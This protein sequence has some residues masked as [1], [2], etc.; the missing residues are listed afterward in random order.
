MVAGFA[1]L[2][3]AIN[4]PDGLVA[5]DYYKD[6]LAINRTLERDDEAQRLGAKARL[7]FDF[8]ANRVAAN[9]SAEP[10]ADQQ[11]RLRLT[12]PTL[13]DQDVT[14]LLRRAGDGTYHASLPSLAPGHW[15]VLLEPEDLFWRLTGRI[16]LPESRMLDLA[17][18]ENTQPQ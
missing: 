11:Y 18:Q 2:V 15:H 14:L 13:E 17:P 4:A 7:Q 8:T 16:L 9:I 6:G 10:F 3:I 1:T 5:D 12:H